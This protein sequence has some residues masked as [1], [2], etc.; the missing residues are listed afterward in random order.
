MTRSI[1]V[2]LYSAP[3]Y[4]WLT[5][6]WS[7]N[8]LLFSVSVSME[9]P[10]DPTAMCWFPRIYLYGNIFHFFIPGNVLYNELI[11]QNPSLRKSVRHSIPNNG[12][13]C[14]NIYQLFFQLEDGRSTSLRN[15]G[16]SLPGYTTSH[17]REHL[18]L[19]GTALTASISQVYFRPRST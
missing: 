17:T 7:G 2:S 4:D 8:G 6:F 13:V 14:H 9:T 12:S 18:F 1:L 15:V 10:V 16:K 5:S 11:S 19:V 3:N